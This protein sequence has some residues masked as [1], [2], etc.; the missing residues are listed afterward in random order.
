M[1]ILEEDDVKTLK[2]LSTF[3]SF[4]YVAIMSDP[5]FDNRMRSNH[6][7]YSNNTVLQISLHKIIEDGLEKHKDL[8]LRLGIWYNQTW[9]VER[10]LQL[11]CDFSKVLI[12]GG[13]LHGAAAERTDI[14]FSQLLQRKEVD[15]DDLCSKDLKWY[16]MH[17]GRAYHFKAILDNCKFE[18]RHANLLIQVLFEQNYKLP[19]STLNL[20]ADHPKFGSPEQQ[21]AIFR[22][23]MDNK[24]F[25]FVAIRVLQKYLATRPAIIDP[26][27]IKHG[28]VLL[29]L[30]TMSK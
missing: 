6:N 7:I 29:E 17:H 19:I 21:F 8:L 23:A 10:L 15:F 25:G 20:M 11:D 22:K 30:L 3:P 1:A 4:D 9:L 28:G 27:Y 14:I 18:E 24:G 2:V 12:E 5:D 13:L 16:A 26:R